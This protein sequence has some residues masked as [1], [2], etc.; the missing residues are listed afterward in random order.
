MVFVRHFEQ[1]KIRKRKYLIFKM[2]HKCNK[3]CSYHYCAKSELRFC[4]GSNSARC[5]SEVHAMV[6]ASSNGSCLK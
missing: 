6:H 3:G 1:S 4:A 5:V 2:C